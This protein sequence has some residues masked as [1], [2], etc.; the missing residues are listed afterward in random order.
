[1]HQDD[2]GMVENGNT[3]QNNPSAQFAYI[4]IDSVT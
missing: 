1:M 2:S 4:I 3:G